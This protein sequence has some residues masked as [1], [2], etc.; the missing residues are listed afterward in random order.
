[1]PPP[2]EEEFEDR[3][4]RIEDYLETI[5]G[6]IREKGYARA[7]DIAEKLAVTPSTVT[8]MIQRL[9]KL[10][11]VIYEKYRGITL[12]DK[13][14]ALAQR[15]ERRHR[16]ISRFLEIL[17]LSG[18]IVYE[19]AEGIEHHVHPVTVDRIELLVDFFEGNPDVMNQLHRFIETEIEEARSEETSD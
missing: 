8:S 12:T 1:M 14:E 7:V 15:I 17:E 18:D 11:F 6:L 3:T 4:A 9:D 19:D 16:V 10:D 13:G 2:S 5:S